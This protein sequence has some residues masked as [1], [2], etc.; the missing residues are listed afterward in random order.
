V[1]VGGGGVGVSGGSVGPRVA[2]GT[3]VLVGTGVPVGAAVGIL[4]SAGVAVTTMIQGVVVGPG[5]AQAAAVMTNATRNKAILT[6]NNR[7]Y[8]AFPPQSLGTPHGAARPAPATQGR[9]LVGA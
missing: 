3:N 2:V 4:V 8:M 1:G 9:R 5:E 7:G 6:G